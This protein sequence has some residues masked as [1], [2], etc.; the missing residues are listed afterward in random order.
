[1][2]YKK[3]T[4]IESKNEY[5]PLKSKRDLLNAIARAIAERNISEIN[6]EERIEPDEL[7]RAVEDEMF[8]ILVE[9]IW[10]NLPE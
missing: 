1:M 8:K 2:L 10:K 3:I 6:D 7:L 9:K 5:R 4:M